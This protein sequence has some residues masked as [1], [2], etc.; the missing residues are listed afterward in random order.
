MP[1]TNIKNKHF[2][3]EKRKEVL[4]Y[5]KKVGNISATCLTYGINRTTFYKW[6]KCNEL[7]ISNGLKRKKNH[8]TAHPYKTKPEV[9]ARVLDFSLTNPTLGCSKI[10]EALM[11]ENIK[12]SSPTI[13]KILVKEKLGT[14]SKR[15]FRL[16]KKHI[17]QGLEVSTDL[18]RKI[19]RND[20]CFKELNKIGTYPGEIMVQDSF[21]VFGLFPNTYIHVVIDTFTSY[22][23]AY[24]WADKSVE[25]AIEL[26]QAKAFKVFRHPK[27]IITDRGYEFTKL[28]KFN[29]SYSKFLQN[30]GIVHEMYSGKEKNWNGFIE[31]YK[32]M[33]FT[34]FGRRSSPNQDVM[35]SN[36]IIQWMK[37]DRLN[38][39]RIVNG[40]PNF[41][42][43]PSKLYKS[44]IR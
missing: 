18:L 26:L 21:P 10:A 6:H 9:T 25:L 12:I 43:S 37:N 40:Y 8:F 24:P 22:S 32:K 41:G 7:D 31:R 14:V 13:Q 28:N 30:H 23:F 38:A 19:G 29:K 1:I 11:L 3:A 34:R 2:S 5:A 16:E 33:F 15:L 44:F 27:I 20:P 39:E 36:E 4:L 17:K 35:S 42:A